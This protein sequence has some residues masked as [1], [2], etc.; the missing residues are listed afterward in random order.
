MYHT[1]RDD[2]LPPPD[3]EK[4]E[5]EKEKE[6]GSDKGSDKAES[7]NGGEKDED[8]DVLTV[9]HN[10]E[11]QAEQVDLPSRPQRQRKQLNKF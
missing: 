3:S 10:P 2:E 5:G 1:T 9:R 11:A 6:N 7:E 4:T 8:K